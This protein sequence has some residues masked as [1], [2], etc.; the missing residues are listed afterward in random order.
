L[1]KDAPILVLDE[2][3]SSLDSKSEAMVQEALEH[4]M[5]GRTTIIIAHRLSTIQHVDTIITIQGG[6]VGEIGS[7]AELAKT[8]GVYAQLLALQTGASERDKKRL[9]EF[10]IAA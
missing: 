8:G 1:L 5:K 7:P 4:L 3:T 6:K 2:A 10:G 9:Q